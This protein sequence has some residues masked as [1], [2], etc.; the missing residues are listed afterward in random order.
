MEVIARQIPCDL[1]PSGECRRSQK[2]KR[3]TLSDRGGPL[4]SGLLGLE[5][6]CDG[7]HLPGAPTAPERNDFQHSLED[8]GYEVALVKVACSLDPCEGACYWRILEERG[9]S[10]E[11]AAG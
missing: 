11:L 4:L 3:E 6:Q 7:H 9:P 1:S 8:Y 5:C 10:S 2:M